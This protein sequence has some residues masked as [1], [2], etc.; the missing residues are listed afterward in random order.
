MKEYD[1]IIIGAG[2]GGI[3]SAYELIKNNP[4]LKIGLFESGKRLEDRQCP[5]N[6][7]NVKT[8]TGCDICSITRGFGGAGAF[9]DGKFNITNDFGGSLYKFIGKNNALNLMKY[10][11]EINVKLGAGNAKFY[12]TQNTEIKRLCEKN[13]MKLLDAE[14]RHLG[15][16]I[17]YS[18][19]KALYS[20]LKEKIE[21]RFES[22][23]DG[24]KVKGNL[25]YVYSNKQVD[26][27]KNCIVAVGR[28]GSQWVQKLCD[29]LDIPMKSNRI[30]LGVRVETRAEVLEHITEKVYESKIIF[31]T[32]KYKDYVRTFCMNPY[33]YV[34]NENI[35]GIIT[36]NGHSYENPLKK[37]P[38]T[39]VALLVSEQFA[40]SFKKSF[41]YGENIVKLSNIL[42]NGAIIQR[43]GDLIQGRASTER[44]I[45][46]NL[47]IPTLQAR[48]GDLSLVLPKRILDNIIEM[49]YNL[50]KVAPGIVADHTLLYGVEIKFYNTEVKINE[51]LET[52]YR[53]LYIIGD[54]SGVTHSLSQAAASGVYVA[55][56]IIKCI[57]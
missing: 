41:E 51:R 15:T 40:E 6:G 36:V 43:F 57:I 37:S 17:N 21:I 52:P 1:V 4:K 38:N 46:Q 11:D 14:V 32:S 19:L 3:Y 7:K 56:C 47:V 12:T 42:G 25:F 33:G 55:R 50:D 30:D 27:C 28:S 22:P 20:V 49:L 29:S 2:P 35:N 24:I 31:K 45:A 9:S 5:I 8:C 39:N 26:I 13:D 16:D 53:G 23:V 34:V 18:I 10:V 44:S 54:G 48:P